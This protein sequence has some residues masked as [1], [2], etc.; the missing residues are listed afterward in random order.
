MKKKYFLVKI[1]FKAR[2]PFAYSPKLYDCFKISCAIDEKTA[3]AN[4]E[5][6]FVKLF[7]KGTPSNCKITKSKIIPTI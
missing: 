5:Q 6:H 4:A 1:F 3:R 7:G 2:H